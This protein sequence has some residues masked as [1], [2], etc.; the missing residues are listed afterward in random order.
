MGYYL[1]RYYILFWFGSYRRLFII[2]L[3][4]TKPKIKLDCPNDIL[5]QLTYDAVEDIKEQIWD[6]L[7]YELD[8]YMVYAEVKAYDRD[9][10]IDTDDE[11]DEDEEKKNEDDSDSE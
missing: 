5:E 11:E 3:T 2:T 4:K 8:Y 1:S 6:V 9:H 10:N 7:K